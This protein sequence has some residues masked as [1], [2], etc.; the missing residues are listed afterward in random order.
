MSEI[1]EFDSI[2]SDKPTV[3]LQTL[4]L[5]KQIV[6]ILVDTKAGLDEQGKM[7]RKMG[8]KI[9]KKNAKMPIEE[10]IQY[11]KDLVPEFEKLVKSIEKGDN[12]TM[13][14][15]SEAKP[16]FADLKE[17]YIATAKMASRFL[18]GEELEDALEG[19]TFSEKRIGLLIEAIEFLEKH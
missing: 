2:A 7:A 19:L 5:G 6:E 10:W 16:K 1:G 18:K 17:N 4:E 14:S 15:I 9:F 12:L 11:A 13:D 3:C 8:L